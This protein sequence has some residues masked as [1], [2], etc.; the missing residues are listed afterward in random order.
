MESKLNIIKKIFTLIGILFLIFCSYKLFVF[1]IPFVIAYFISS[2]L[3]PLVNKLS[4]KTNITRKRSSIIILTAFFLITVLVIFLSLSKI[5]EEV[6]KFSGTI[7]TYIENIIN[8]FTSFEDNKFLNEYIFVNEATKNIVMRNIN[9]FLYS[10]EEAIKLYITNLISSLKFIPIVFINFIIT[11][12]A[13]YF[14]ISDKFSI[15][16]KLEHQFSKKIVYKVRDKI[17]KISNTLICY[18]KAE[19]ILIFISFSVVLIGLYIYKFIGMKIEYPLLI[20]ILIGVVDALPILGAGIIMIP[21]SIILF[22]KNDVSL[23]FSILG[24]Y[25]I[26]LCTKQTLEPKIVSSKIG[27]HPIF[28]LLAMYTGFK[29]LG[30][31]G[32]IVGP[33]MLI[34]FKEIF[35]NLLDIGLINYFN[36]EY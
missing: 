22:I 34:I 14:L 17:E 23:G 36:E 2:I 21:W 4:K 32:I 35:Q 9:D 10:F 24:L 29:I 25:L 31:I 18:L 26:V 28:T 30:F 1:Y 16:D 7:N 20:A 5:I 13:L 12:V 27:V 33:I 8:F 11:I 6:S 15:L 3:N 19:I